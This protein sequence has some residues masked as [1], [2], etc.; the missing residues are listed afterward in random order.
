MIGA[1]RLDSGWS[2]GGAV[3]RIDARLLP[4][5]LKDRD[6]GDDGLKMSSAGLNR[7]L[8]LYD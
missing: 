7:P 4:R 5:A 6:D 1:E 3:V 2:G 8:Y